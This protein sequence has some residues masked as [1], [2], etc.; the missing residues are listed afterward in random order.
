[1]FNYH[2]LPAG[3]QKKV[4]ECLTRISEGESLDIIEDYIEEGGS[5]SHLFEEM[6]LRLFVND[7]FDRDKKILDL[8]DEKDHQEIWDKLQA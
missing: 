4:V 2:E 5:Y 8:L 6:R 7:L 1:M 3:L